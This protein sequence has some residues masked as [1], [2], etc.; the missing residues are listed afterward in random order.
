MSGYVPVSIPKEEGMFCF[1]GFETS[2]SKVQ[3]T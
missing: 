2:A 1:E 3:I